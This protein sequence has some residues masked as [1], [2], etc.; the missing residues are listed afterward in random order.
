M[1]A[2]DFQLQHAAF[3][4]WLLG[5]GTDNLADLDALKRALPIVLEECVSETQ[6]T[7]ILDF[8]VEG[9]TL[10]EIGK[11]YG[12]NRST[13]SR[14]IHRGLNKAYGYLRF[15]SPLFI[16]APKARGY[17]SKGRKRRKR[18][19]EKKEKSPPPVGAG[20]RADHVQPAAPGRYDREPERGPGGG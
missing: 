15:V 12:V 6:R 5:E 16:N 9:L 7:Y 8:F 11:K 20:D 14:G 3:D 10:E 2:T 13:V 19:D 17:L 1:G 18:S 4:L